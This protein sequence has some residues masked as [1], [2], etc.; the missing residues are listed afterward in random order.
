[1]GNPAH[2]L[3]PS[4]EEPEA[5][6]EFFQIDRFPKIGL[7]KPAMSMNVR[8]AREQVFDRPQL[9]FAIHNFRPL[10]DLD[11]RLR[12]KSDVRKCFG[13]RAGQG[14]RVVCSGH[15]KFRLRVEMSLEEPGSNLCIL[16]H[17]QK[18]RPA[19]QQ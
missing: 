1:M 15:H 12:Q 6:S 17:L 18:V 8:T 5:A 13:N 2:S 9:G 11:I 3:K 10:D 19:G 4:R 16:Y 7:I 14:V